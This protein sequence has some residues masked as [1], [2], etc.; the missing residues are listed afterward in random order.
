[1]FRQDEGIQMTRF[2]RRQFLRASSA[3]AAG[4]A[5]PASAVALH[6]APAAK[7]LV[8]RYKPLG[9]TGWKVGDISAGS[10]Q[11]DPGVFNYIFESGINLIDTG[12]QYV[13][14]EE[15]LG[16]V[17]PKWRRK[18]FVLDKWDPPVVTS[19]VTK[20]ALLEALDVSLKKL[21]TTY[22][23]CMMI[24]SIGHPRYGGLERIQNPAIYEAW[25]QAKR[26]GKIRFTGASSHGVRMIEEMEWAIDTDRFD[27]ILIGANFLTHGVEP[28]LKKARA[29]G[30]GT[31]AMKTM[32][33][34]KSDLNI[35]A[36]QNRQTNARQAC[37][38]WILASDLFD[39]LVV[40]MAS[41]DRVGEYLAV[42]G[43]TSLTAEDERDLGVLAAEIGPLYCRPGCDA[44][45]GSCPANVP[46][47]DV[48]RY[49]MY[50]EHYGEEKFA[51]ERYRRVPVAERAA[52]CVSCKAP[53][54]KACRYGLG[55]RARLV[56][57]H[58]Q[59]TI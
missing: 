9:R 15:L 19:T 10:G 27:V 35:R 17:L 30:I 38:K 1:M 21:N 13:G 58:G 43:A 59:L 12:A 25:D 32:T 31:I 44:C 45:L 11:R 34:Y 6:G 33:V 36:L 47:A 49:K 5:V 20:S 46:I 24:H 51:M 53:C 57:A 2:S 29:K 8:K 40:S 48:L 4:A 52:A 14:H 39:T 26:L 50:F 22:V 7:T 42:S 28:L 41:Y 37:L 55:V 56:E 18:V 54:E 23:D 16:K 3:L